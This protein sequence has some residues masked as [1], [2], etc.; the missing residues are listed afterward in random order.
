[1]KK[2]VM[3]GMVALAASMASSAFASEQTQ[4]ERRLFRFDFDCHFHDNDVA[5][6]AT[7]MPTPADP[8]APSIP[9]IGNDDH[10][11]AQAR[12]FAYTRGDDLSSLETAKNLTNAMTVSCN[13]RLVYADGA[14]LDSGFHVVKIQAPNAPIE[15]VI[16]RKDNNLPN[17]E[18]MRHRSVL[19]LGRDQLRGECQVSARPVRLDQ[20]ST[21]LN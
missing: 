8:T 11:T 17:S 3:L 13:G 18:W 20:N 10:C 16:A 4:W 12:V 9:N 21:Q 14:V 6:D 2:I 1:M 7:T 5:A 19:R 15:I